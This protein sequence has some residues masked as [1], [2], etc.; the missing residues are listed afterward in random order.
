MRDKTIT[1]VC[2]TRDGIEWTSVVVK[3]DGTEPLCQDAMPLAIPDG[4]LEEQLAAIEL[5]DGIAE[6]LKGDIAVALRT[7]ELLLRVMRFPT[8]DAAEIA[9]MIGFQV[10]KISP[11]PPEQLA[12]SHEI[13]QQAGETSLVLMAA[14]RRE[15]I[16][17]IG[18][19]FRQ[20]G[21][22]IHRIDARILGWVKLLQDGGHLESTG[23]AIAVIDDGI[24]FSLAVF[25]DGVPLA[26][27]TLDTEPGSMEMA[28]EL[29]EE[30]AYTLTT[31]DTEYELPAPSGI[32]F[33]T[34]DEL[35]DGLR[36][37]LSKHCE[38]PVHF[39]R[40]PDLPPLSEGIVRRTL[41]GGNRIELIPSEWID[42]E[43]RKRL[44]RK[45]T[46]L[47]AAIAAVWLAVLLVFF[48]VYK[49]RAARLAHVE[50]QLAAIAPEARQALQ[51]HEKLKALK[52]YTDRSDSAL[53]CLREVTRLLPSG[54]IDFVSYNYKKGKGV[55]LRGTAANDNMV[56]SFFDALAKSPLFEGL[57]DQSTTTKTTKGV[58]RAVFSVTLVLPSKEGGK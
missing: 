19:T 44:R 48:A 50:A 17:G 41:E 34:L 54:D 11:F 53:E 43:K 27:R 49:V 21:V 15:S 46:I 51:N 40:L 28:T 22:R 16:D 9:D 25:L 32:H 24:D 55:S 57:K 23:C 26:F 37:K 42:H 18:E 33:W 58:R 36:A 7:S 6:H 4:K 10:D 20:K 35:P 12:I 30:V 2:R 56:Y 31:L 39:N 38:A 14:A 13:L 5:P 52:L 45:F 47:S 1:A 29:A 8:A 3:A